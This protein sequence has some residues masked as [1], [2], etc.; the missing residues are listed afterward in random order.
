MWL[1]LVALINKFRGHKG[2]VGVEWR[3]ACTVLYGEF[4][5]NVSVFV[6]NFLEN[7][8]NSHAWRTVYVPWAVAKSRGWLATVPVMSRLSTQP[9]LKYILRVHLDIFSQHPDKDYSYATIAA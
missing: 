1:L 6:K 2:R 8:R 9:L 3:M 5:D 7:P 4:N